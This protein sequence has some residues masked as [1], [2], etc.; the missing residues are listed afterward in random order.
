MEKCGAVIKLMHFLCLLLPLILFLLHFPV[1]RGE[2]I[3]IAF[4]FHR[5]PSTQKKSGIQLKL[6]IFLGA[7]KQ[8]KNFN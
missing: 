6:K 2:I 8:E 3:I 5:S 1:H 7:A 4:G